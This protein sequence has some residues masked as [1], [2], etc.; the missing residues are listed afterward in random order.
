VGS[1][2]RDERLNLLLERIKQFPEDFERVEGRFT[3]MKWATWFA[4]HF[5]SLT[6]SEQKEINH[7]LE[8]HLRDHAL[9]KIVETIA[10]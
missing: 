9:T 3:H 5:P 7:A 4:M 10:N 2:P 8:I 6:P 1:R